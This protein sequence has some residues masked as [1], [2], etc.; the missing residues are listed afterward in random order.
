M[1]E[2]LRNRGARIAVFTH[3]WLAVGA[4]AQA[5][6]LGQFTGLAN[7][8]TMLAVGASLM[9]AYGVMRLVRTGEPAPISSPWIAWV[10]QHRRPMIIVTVLSALVALWAVCGLERIY[11]PYG[12]IAIP[13]VALYLLPSLD[14]YGR[15][16]GLRQVP[17]LKAPLIAAVWTLTTTGF[18]TGPLSPELFPVVAQ[19][20]ALQFA[21]ILGMAMAFD[22]MDMPNDAPTLR[23][24]P[25]ML[26]GKGA[27]VLAACMMIPWVFFLAWQQVDTGLQWHLLLPLFGYVIAALV[28]LRS[29]A[30]RSFAYGAVLMDGLLILIPLLAWCGLWIDG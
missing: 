28:L 7:W 1:P 21:F 13:L 25:Q 23:T 12:L 26:G 9:A 2:G 3:V 4:M 6:W 18:A 11:A 5:W 20:A 22:G 24:A 29:G 14:A 19:L 8:R 27:R 17:M 15:S 30:H 16:R 10:A